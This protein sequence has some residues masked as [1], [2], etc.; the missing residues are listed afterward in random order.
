[1]PQKAERAQRRN[2]I[3]V[4]EEVILRGPSAEASVK[5]KVDTGAER[6]SIDTEL[7][8]AM[9]LGPSVRR[10][11]TRAA[12]A[13]KAQLREV[14]KAVL[15]IAGK[16]FTVNAAITDRTDMRY[17]IIVGM[18]ILARSGFHVDPGKT[19]GEAP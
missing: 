17:P 11:R 6:T 4:I 15:V 5:A 8:R 7:A 14:M 12:A 19:N 3:G 10:V 2:V 18:D 13:D 9:G 16:E 1:M